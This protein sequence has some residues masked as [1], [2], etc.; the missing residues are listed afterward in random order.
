MNLELLY[1]KA[2][3]GQSQY[4]EYYL[5]SVKNGSDIEYNLFATPEVHEK[6]KTLKKG[7]RFNIV[8]LAEQRGKKIVTSYSVTLPEQP[9][10]QNPPAG[11]NSE[12]PLQS[13]Q[14]TNSNGVKDG[15]YEVM[16][17]SYKDSQKIQ[18]QLNGMVD[19]NRIAITLFIARSKI[20]NNGFN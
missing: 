13:K 3:I 2:I 7:Q 17:E 12:T 1:D 4:G 19:V 14:P 9:K 20:Y 15:Y 10:Q 8:K 11:G 16:L 6:L 5:Y 18:E